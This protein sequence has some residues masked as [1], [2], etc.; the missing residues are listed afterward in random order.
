MVVGNL[1]SAEPS[2]VLQARRGNW[3][4]DLAS[5]P[6]RERWKLQLAADLLNARDPGEWDV[7]IGLHLADVIS[8][9]WG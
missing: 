4:I 1:D 5:A 8:G 7:F 3:V 2:A 6:L 9:S